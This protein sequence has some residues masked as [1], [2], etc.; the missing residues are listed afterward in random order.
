MLTRRRLL[1][2]GVASAAL[3]VFP[4]LFAREPLIIWG[5]PVSPTVLLAVAA[6][7][8]HAHTLQPFTV[9]SWQHPDQL[10][11]GL[12]NG[13]IQI[14]V[15]PSYVAANFRA[16]GQKVHLYNIMTKGLLSILSKG[17]ALSEL[18]QLAGQKLVMPFKQDMPDLVLQL[19]AKKHGFALSDQITYTATPP[20]AVAFFL[21]KDFPHALL[22]EPLATVALLKGQ[23]EHLKVVRSF[24][25]EKVWNQ[26]FGTQ[27]GIPQAGLMVSEN[28]LHEQSAFL[29]ALQQDLVQAVDWV[30][31]HPAQA[32][33]M[34]TAYLPAPAAA[35]ERAFATSALCALRSTDI[36]EEILAFML[37]LYELNPKIVGGKKP[38]ASLFI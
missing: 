30:A 18:K 11:A 23:Q 10:R 28:M 4:P 19:L 15:V 26:S 14:S 33:D 13:S 20:E 17:E 31:Q 7:I 16:Q 35:L 29:A 38:D 36:Q 24:S 6:K 27:H 8:G 22:P 32:A 3:S 37:A 2:A 12:L 25:L 1:Q 9:K 34:A 5:P 21:Q